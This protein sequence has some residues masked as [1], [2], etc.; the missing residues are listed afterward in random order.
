[1]MA[2]EAALAFTGIKTNQMAMA[3]AKDI[4]KRHLK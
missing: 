2:K 1:M 4:N 3:F